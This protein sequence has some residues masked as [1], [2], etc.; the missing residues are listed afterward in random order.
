MNAAHWRTTAN[1]NHDE[2]WVSEKRISARNVPS[3][4]A[5][6]VVS[7]WTMYDCDNVAGP[8]VAISVAAMTSRRSPRIR[9]PSAQVSRAMISRATQLT[10]RAVI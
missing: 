4:N 6:N 2:R 10:T 9:H 8:S 3:T 7:V 5:T 1:A